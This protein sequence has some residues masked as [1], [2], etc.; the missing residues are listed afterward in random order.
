[1]VICAVLA[2]AVL[3]MNYGTKLPSLPFQPIPLDRPTIADSDGQMTVVVDTE[4][5]RVLIL[6]ANGDITGAIDC[7]TVDC[8]VDVITDVCVS[9]GR[10]Y[11]AGC[12]L[13]PD[14]NMVA[15]ERVVA[16][17]RSGSLQGIVYEDGGIRLSVP[18]IKQICDAPGGIVISREDYSTRQ[19]KNIPDELIESLDGE[20]PVEGTATEIAAQ[21]KFIFANDNET[22]E[23]RTI[24]GTLL[25]LYDVAFDAEGEGHYVALDE[26][27]RAHV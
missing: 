19:M 9:E 21:I 6:N 8:P 3:F 22:R 13:E 4:T 27:G 10:V 25:E 24:D 15:D 26:I 2:A 7:K 12:L 17:D 11:I 18:L 5:R 1:M 23:L 20:Q 16:Y 14:S